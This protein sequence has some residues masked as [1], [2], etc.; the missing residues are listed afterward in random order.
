MGC[1][2]G[3]ARLLLVVLNIVFMLGGLAIF[4]VGFI[5]RYGKTIYEPFL[6]TGIDELEKVT[7]DTGLAALSVDDINLGEV[8]TGL[9][10]GLIIGGVTLFVFSFVGCCGACCKVGFMLWLYIIALVTIFVGE[11]VAIGLLYGKPDLVTDQLKDSLSEYEGIASAQVYSL[12]WNIIMIQFKCCGVDNYK[13]FSESTSWNKTL[14]VQG[15][16]FTLE[17][18]V[19]CCKTLPSSKDANHFQCA[20][21]YDSLTNTGMTGC[22]KTIWDLSMANTALMVPILTVLAIFQIAF[23]LFA[24]TVARSEEKSVSPV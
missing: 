8:M 20:I 7:K 15:R 19:A 3:L 4:V 9:A 17:T 10:T 21:K 5:L 16:T 11:M 2:D 18:P 13:D 22:Y 23:I 12:A 6:K 14:Q 1:F 24:I